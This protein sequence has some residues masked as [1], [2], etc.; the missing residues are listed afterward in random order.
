M[1]YD[2]ATFCHIHY[3]DAKTY[4]KAFNSRRWNDMK[5][6]LSGSL[7]VVALISSNVFA[8]DATQEYV[9][10]LPTTT[11]TADKNDDYT[12]KSTSSATRTNTPIEEIPQSVVSVTRELIEDQGAETLSDA[13]KNVSNIT[14]IDARDSNNAVFRIRGFTSATVVDGV[15]MPAYFPN[16]ESV[17]NI[18]RIDVVKGPAGGLFGSS[19]GQGSFGALGGSIALTT[20]EPSLLSNRQI[21]V[22]AGSYGEKALSLDINQAINSTVAVR[23]VGEV[24]ESDSETDSVFLKENHYFRAYHG[25]PTMIPK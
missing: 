7:S 20:S 1:R 21:A 19:Q 14:T 6:L 17:L 18:E 24:D 15:A 9:V 5:G 25:H 16:Q 3:G 4:N 2:G 13:L 10:T 11:V 8:Q 23:V 22:K 12:V